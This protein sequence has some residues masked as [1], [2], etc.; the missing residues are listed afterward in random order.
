MPLA[1]TRVHLRLFAFV[2]SSLQTFAISQSSAIIRD[3]TVRGAVH[4][5]AILFCVKTVIH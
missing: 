1:V 2:R 5:P 3:T 4:D